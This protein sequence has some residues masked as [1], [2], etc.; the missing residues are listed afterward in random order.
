MRPRHEAEAAIFEA[1]FRARTILLD[2]TSTPRPEITTV[3]FFLDAIIDMI[4]AE[5]ELAARGAIE[6]ES[7]FELLVRAAES[8]AS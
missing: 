2:V 3:G 1:Y 7:M 5:A 8:R 6:S 4:R